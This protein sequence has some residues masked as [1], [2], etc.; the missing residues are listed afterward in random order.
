MIVRH[1]LNQNC[2]SRSNRIPSSFFAFV[3]VFGVVLVAVV[4]ENPLQGLVKHTVSAVSLLGLRENGRRPTEY[5]DDLLRPA[6][7]SNELDLMAT[8]QRT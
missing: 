1:V 6:E 3:F 4:D 8:T 7:L 2:M 5:N